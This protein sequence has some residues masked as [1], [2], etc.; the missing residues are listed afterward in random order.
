MLNK[1]QRYILIVAMAVL[2][3]MILVPPWRVYSPHYAVALGY[4]PIGKPP[5]DASGID[6]YRLAFQVFGLAVVTAGAMVLAA[7]RA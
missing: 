1:T 4:S 3:L 5:E 6:L 7:K 2:V